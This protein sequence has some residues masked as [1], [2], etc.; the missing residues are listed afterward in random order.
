MKWKGVKV[1]LRPSTPTTGINGT[2]ER[3]RIVSIPS[4]GQIINIPRPDHITYGTVMAASCERANEWNRNDYYQLYGV[5]LSSALKACQQLGYADDALE[6]LNQMKELSNSSNI[7]ES[8]TNGNASGNTNSNGSSNTNGH[9]HYNHHR[10]KPLQGPDDVAYRLAISACARSGYINN[11][12][13]DNTSRPPRWIAWIKLLREMEQVTGPSPDVIAYTAAIS[14]CAVAWEYIRA[15]VLNLMLLPSLLSFQNV[16]LLV[17]R[18]VTTMKK[19][20]IT[21]IVA[22]SRLTMNS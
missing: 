11:T 10:R 3:K 17:Q 22:L 12:N 13:G 21:L 19:I 5:S 7:G 2:T 4:N 18:K 6:Y 8:N 15:S 16:L 14:G 9:H 1:L 20:I